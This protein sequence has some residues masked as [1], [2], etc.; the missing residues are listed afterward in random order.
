[1][2]AGGLC[3]VVY[4]STGNAPCYVFL[5]LAAWRLI[6]VLPYVAGVKP[7]IAAATLM[8]GAAGIWG[9]FKSVLLL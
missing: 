5:W 6:T 9:W 3:G 2:A 7:A 8:T 4:K 1:M